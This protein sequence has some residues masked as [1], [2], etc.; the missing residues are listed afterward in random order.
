MSSPRSRSCPLT[1]LPAPCPG[2]FS[3]VCSVEHQRDW[4]RQG[5]VEAQG[6]ARMEA[7]LGPHGEGVSVEPCSMFLQSR[8]LFSAVSTSPCFATVSISYSVSAGSSSPRPASVLSCRLFLS[9]PFACLSCTSLWAPPRSASPPLGFLSS[10]VSGPLCLA[11]VSL[12]RGS[13]TLGREDVSPS[14]TVPG[15]SEL[16]TPFVGGPG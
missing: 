3:F 14:L 1:L 5:M 4:G 10:S 16:P 6:Q 12:G 2:A 7:Q 11:S 9:L 8:F 13:P 15:R